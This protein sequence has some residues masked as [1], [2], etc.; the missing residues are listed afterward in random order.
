[1]TSQHPLSPDGG[2]PTAMR[3]FIHRLRGKS[4]SCL[5]I[6]D[7]RLAP[8]FWGGLRLV[9]GVFLSRRCVQSISQKS[10]VGEWYLLQ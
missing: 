8:G 7:A 4:A 9:F 6:D 3:Q 1:M 2:F 10:M 5:Y